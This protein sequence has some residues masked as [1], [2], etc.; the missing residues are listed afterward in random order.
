MKTQIERS[1]YH[2][3]GHIILT[4]LTGYSCDKVAL[5]ADAD[6]NAFTVQ[7]YGNDLLLITAITNYKTDPEIFNELPNEI[8][9]KTLSTAH[10]A[11]SILLAGSVTESICLNDGLISPEME[12]VVSGPD[13]TRS[14][15]IDFLLSKILPGHDPDFIKNKTSELFEFF[16]LE[17]FTNAADNLAKAMLTSS[18]LTLNKEEIEEILTNTGFLEFITQFQ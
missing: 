11:T 9:N 14:E 12:V 7:N 1:A 5:N 3:A 15:Q 6:G 8:K 2:E 4:Y 10:K 17:E 18:D 13:L 16:V